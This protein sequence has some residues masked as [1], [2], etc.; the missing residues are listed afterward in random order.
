MKIKLS[1]L[2]FLIITFIFF[3]SCDIDDNI[4]YDYTQ[5]KKP[6]IVIDKSYSMIR[7][8]FYIILIQSD[9]TIVKVAGIKEYEK[10]NHGDT[11]K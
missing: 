2:I 11:L 8:N 3:I 5:I 10:Y 1:K 9:R 4:I 6:A 7:G